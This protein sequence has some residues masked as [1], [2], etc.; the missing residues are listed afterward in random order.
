M[1]STFVHK[2]KEN[3]L[4]AQSLQYIIFDH[5]KICSNLNLCDCLWLVQIET[6][7]TML[8]YL[9]NRIDQITSQREQVIHELLA[10]SDSAICMSSS[11]ANVLTYIRLGRTVK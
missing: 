4:V 11:D 10:F 9:T 3:P 1:H 5:N 2:N 8:D 7:S 6:T